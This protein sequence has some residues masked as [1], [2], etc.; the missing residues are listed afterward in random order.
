MDAM[1]FHAAYRLNPNSVSAS[2]IRPRR[3]KQAFADA[4]YEVF[5]LTG[6]A[7]ERRHKFRELRT[8]VR[9]GKRF[10]FMYSESATIPPM[11]G[12]PNH[13]PH[14]FLDAQIFRFLK[15]QGIPQAVFYRDIYW[16]FP[17]YVE[18]VG[19]LLATVMR[20]M[21][22]AELALYKKYMTKVYVPSQQM[23]TYIPELNGIDVGALPPGGYN[24]DA[25]A[26][27][28]PINLLYVGGIGPHYQLDELVAAVKVLPDVS[29]TICTSADGWAGV[30]DQYAVEGFS[31]IDVVHR[32]GD[33]LHQLFQRSNI[34]V[35]MVKPSEYWGFAVP[36][37]LFEYVNYGK[38]VLVSRGTLAG[39]LVESHGWGW[40]IDN[41]RTEITSALSE[42]AANPAQIDAAA[43]QVMADRGGHT[44]LARAE[45]VAE[46]LS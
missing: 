41:D 38:P 25:S 4:D 40:V 36:V 23:A 27:A 21:Y 35:I 16:R 15:N 24:T 14:P 30:A 19:R 13:F 10:S 32:S 39:E 18:R 46:D 5:D 8:A 17:D 33:G 7:A 45:Q 2:A 9:E 29:L 28:H 34:A 44:W 37:K 20:P 1:I 31:N 42:L 12:D 3:M 22:L 43:K 11:I 6:T 26:S